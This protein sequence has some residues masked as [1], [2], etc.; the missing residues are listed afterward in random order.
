MSTGGCNCE[1]RE[2]QASKL[3]MAEG[4]GIGGISE[5]RKLATTFYDA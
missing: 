2:Y 5:F 3:A 1:A 4:M